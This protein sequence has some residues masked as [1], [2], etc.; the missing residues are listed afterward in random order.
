MAPPPPRSLDGALD[1]KI[2]H[3]I[4]LMLENRSYDQ[5][6][7]AI[8]GDEY[9]GVRAGTRL[10][11]EARDGSREWVS[12][13]H[14]APPDRF[15]PDPGHGFRAVDRQI[16]GL[17]SGQPADMTG[18]AQRFVT[19]HPLVGRSR[20]EQY[21]TLYG[22]GRLPVLQRLAKEY[23][24]CT[25][26]FGSL[27]SST[28]PNRMF[29]HAGTSAGA[30]RAGAYYSRIRGQM[31]FDKLGTKSP[32]TWRVYF[33]DMPHLWLAGDVW[34][35]TFSGHLRFMRSFADDVRL[36]RLATYTFVEPQH[37]IPPW[38]SQHPAGGVSHGEKLIASLYNTL[39]SNPRVFDKSLLLIVYDE[40]G[41]FYDHVVPPGYPGWRAQCPG[42]DYEVVPPDDA[43]GTGDGPEKG[44]GFDT[45]GPRV[46]A[47]VVSPWIERGSVFGW[48][49]SD[50]SKRAT[51]DHTSILATVGAMTGVWVDSK[52]ARAATSL[53]LTIN[54]TAPRT[55]YPPTLSYDERVYRANG[56]RE[57]VASDDDA[58]VVG[59]A[60]ELREAW[61]AEHGQASPVEMVQ[62]FQ[63]LLGV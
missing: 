47:V 2:E 33:H 43:R 34:T 49:A 9:D 39:V 32:Q 3:F 7:G 26:W 50:P 19:D 15:W 6:L 20:I 36:D 11:Y 61:A 25:H 12:I 24:V 18:F 41:G 45:L 52:R 29:A 48:K 62:R 1:G 23:G 30:T 40:H 51:F 27:P 44:Y 31:I 4:V 59:V 37:V 8:D 60:G 28:A 42:S 35:K 55:D 38:S 21:V 58:A 16:R 46:P 63:A 10:A 56:F 57:E 5:M 54:R 22:E 13:A 17:G 53:A 14:G